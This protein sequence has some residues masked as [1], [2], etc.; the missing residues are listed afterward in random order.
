MK[1]D[2][3]LT[4]DTFKS[5]EKDVQELTN[6]YTKKIEE[7]AAAKEEDLMKI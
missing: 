3:A 1:A 4:E 7:L 6:K 5:Y 2:N